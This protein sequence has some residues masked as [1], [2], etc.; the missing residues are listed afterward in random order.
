MEF[1][2]QKSFSPLML[3]L[4]IARLHLIFSKVTRSTIILMEMHKLLGRISKNKYESVSAPSMV[5]VNK[6]FKDS[7]LNKGQYP[8]IWITKLED[9]RVKIYDLNSSFQK[10]NS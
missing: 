7:S 4:G 2:T 3:R 1:S 6:Q 8:D 9:F 10:M 5:K